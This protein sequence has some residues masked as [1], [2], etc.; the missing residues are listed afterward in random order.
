MEN[1]DRERGHE[2]VEVTIVVAAADQRD[3]EGHGDVVRPV[4]LPAEEPGETSRPCERQSEE[5]PEGER[6]RTYIAPRMRVDGLEDEAKVEIDLVALR[7]VR[8]IWWRGHDREETHRKVDEDGGG[9]HGE[10]PKGHANGI[11]PN[12]GGPEE[13]AERD[14]ILARERRDDQDTAE[15]NEPTLERAHHEREKKEEAERVRKDRVVER[16]PQ[17][18]GQHRPPAHGEERERRRDGVV[19]EQA[20]EEPGASE[21]REQI[22][23]EETELHLET[24]HGAERAWYE[25]EGPRRHDRDTVVS[26]QGLREPGV[27]PT[28]E[29]EAIVERDARCERRKDEE[30]DGRE[31]DG[32]RRPGDGLVLQHE[33]ARAKER[34]AEGWERAA[35]AARSRHPQTDPEADSAERRCGAEEEERIFEWRRSVLGRDEG[36][37]GGERERDVA[38]RDHERW[39]FAAVDGHVPIRVIGHFQ[40]HRRIGRAACENVVPP[41]LRALVRDRRARAVGDRNGDVDP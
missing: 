30:R 37:T 36:L 12:V 38:R 16:P 29:P 4:E 13:R 20:V 27:D 17:A 31:R 9:A 40:D 2:N 21:C 3:D 5:H 7:P 11:T 8:K 35:P 1:E 18:E 32:E 34:L 28:V 39:D 23:E 24:G 19:A 14:E 22:E 41:R 26:A 33:I 15:H 6:R 25:A 10:A